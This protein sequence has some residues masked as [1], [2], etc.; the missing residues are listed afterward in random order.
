LDFRVELPVVAVAQREDPANA[1][2]RLVEQL[3]V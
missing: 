2:R 1:D 3:G